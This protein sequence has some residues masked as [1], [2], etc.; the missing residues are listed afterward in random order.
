[1]GSFHTLAIV[2]SA[3]LDIRAHAPLRIYFF[4]PFGKY[5]VVRLLDHRVV[6]SLTFGGTPILFSRAAA[7][8]FIPTNSAK[9]SPFSHPPQH[10]LFHVLL[11]L[12][13]PTGVR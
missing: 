6:L 13:I 7:P 10:L 9:C 1:M 3:A 4:D 12:A 11:I 5:L 2:D 8:V